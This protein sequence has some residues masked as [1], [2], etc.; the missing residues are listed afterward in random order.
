MASCMKHGINPYKRLKDTLDRIPDTK[1]SLLHDL[2]AG[3]Q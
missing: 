3:P 2:L 1:L